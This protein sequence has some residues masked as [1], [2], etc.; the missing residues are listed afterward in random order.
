MGHGAMSDAVF[1][2]ISGAK[3]ELVIFDA[4]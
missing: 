2:K 3:L 4:Y 1:L